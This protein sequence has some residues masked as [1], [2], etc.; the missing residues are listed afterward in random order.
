MLP[1]ATRFALLVNPNNRNVEPLTRETQAAGSAI[2]RQIEILA[3]STT[4]DI[5]AAFAS[6]VQKR[7]DALVVRP[8]HFLS[9]VGFNSRHWRCTTLPV[10]YPFATLSKRAD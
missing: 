5:D 1:N 3:V 8:D 4:R 9:A 10:I 7:T 6:L 2:G